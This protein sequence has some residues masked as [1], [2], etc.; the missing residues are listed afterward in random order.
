MININYLRD[1]IIISSL[2]SSITCTFIQ[3]TKGLFKSSKFISLYSLLLNIITG[4]LFSYSFTNLSFP[5]NLWI[6]LFSFIEADS[7]YK[8]FEGKLLSYKDINNK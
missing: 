6:G 1:I 5:H 3:K 8:A 2:I 4:I 7:I